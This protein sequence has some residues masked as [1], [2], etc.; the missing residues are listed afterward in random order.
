MAFS[1]LRTFFIA[2]GCAM[3]AACSSLPPTQT[4][5]VGDSEIAWVRT[6]SAPTTV[7]FQS[8]LGDGMSPWAA[9]IE[10]LPSNAATF[11]YDRPAY[12]AS[13]P[14]P[15]APSNP[16]DVAR[17]LR[18]A[19]TATGTRPPYLLVGH[20]L[21]GQYQYAYARLFPDEV[22]GLLLIDPTHPD[23]WTSLQRETP[24]VAATISALRATVFSATMRAEFDGQSACL[25]SAPPLTKSVP[26]RILVSTRPEIGETPAFRSV[27]SRLRTD[28]L[29]K[30]PGATMHPVAGA[31]HY[32]QKDEPAVVAAEIRAMLSDVSRTAP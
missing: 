31:G 17:E 26:T 25:D 6:G 2:M 32:I 24:A 28:W 1:S 9:V 4:I 10:R 22:A 7:V 27:I 23:H 11:A 15:K 18:E 16:C 13:R 3:A 29:S 21:G 8:G 30:L 14:A 19:L 5:Q 20:S 12:G